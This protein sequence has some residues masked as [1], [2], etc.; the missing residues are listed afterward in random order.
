MV[1]DTTSR[2][3]VPRT[4]HLAH[5]LHTPNPSVELVFAK[6]DR[7]EVRSPWD[8]RFPCAWADILTRR[9]R[10]RA[11]PERIKPE[12]FG[13]SD[14]ADFVAT[15]R[16]Q[17]EHAIDLQWRDRAGFTPASPTPCASISYAK[18]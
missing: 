9:E 2:L 13:S 4:H 6:W 11:F 7:G 14:Q 10:V 16:L 5:S 8:H 15:R 18:V 1:F 12:W 17:R 3:R